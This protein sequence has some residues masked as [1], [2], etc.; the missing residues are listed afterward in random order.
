MTEITHEERRAKIAARVAAGK[1]PDTPIQW[2][3]LSSA[4]DYC[5]KCGV[6]DIWYEK[7]TRRW[8][9]SC[10]TLHFEGAQEQGQ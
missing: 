3:S 2:Q 4:F 1:Q 5:P 6:A 9:P 7:R 8:C 10:D